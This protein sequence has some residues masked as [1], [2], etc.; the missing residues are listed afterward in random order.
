MTEPSNVEP[1]IGIRQ[2]PETANRTMFCNFLK[3]VFCHRKT[4]ERITAIATIALAVAAGWALWDTRNVLEQNQRAWI[5]P[6][7]PIIEGDL[8]SPLLVR[9]PFENTGKSAA[10]NT[11][12]NR[13]AY[14]F[15]VKP[16]ASGIPYVGPE[17]NAWPINNNCVLDVADLKIGRGTTV[18]PGG[19]YSDFRYIFSDAKDPQIDKMK[20]KTL[21]VAIYGCFSYLTYGKTRHSPYCFYWQAYRDKDVKYATFETCPVSASTIKAD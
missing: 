12:D 14:P 1:V 18:Y 17:T 15:E 11:V 21:S 7:A 20:R 16:D 3:R 19:K 4:A 8:I 6:E 2:S 9:T 5:A 10:L 13:D